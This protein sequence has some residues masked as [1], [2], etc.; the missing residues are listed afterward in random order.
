MHAMMQT[1][2][3][4]RDPTC[5]NSLSVMTTYTKVTTGSKQVEVIVKNLTVILITT[6][7]GI[8]VTQVV[9]VNAVPQVEVVPRTLEKL[10]EMQG[11]QQ[12]RI[13]VEW[14]REVLFQ[15]LDLSFLEGWSDENQVATPCPVS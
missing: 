1:L 14:R 6:T 15:Q 12:T 7:K 13:S 2:K 8:K 9:A 5:L 4:V 10:D 11:I 3:G